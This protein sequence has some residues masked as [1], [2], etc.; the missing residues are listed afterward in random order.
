MDLLS[1][2]QQKAAEQQARDIL[3]FAP[4]AP[5][6]RISA[7]TGQG[8]SNLMRVVGTVSREF[9]RR[10]STG[11]LNRFFQEALSR[12]SP[13]ARGGRSPRL[14]YIT[15]AETAPPTFIAMCSAPANIDQS[16]RRFVTN[17]IR[18]TSDLM[19]PPLRSAFGGVNEA[20]ATTQL[21]RLPT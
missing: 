3:H 18:K 7:T 2:E 16:Y 15:Q 17:Q 1:K 12:H 11:A 6:V 20:R 4:W 19:V 10:V 9:H 21:E 8:V 14:Y 5:I 13:P